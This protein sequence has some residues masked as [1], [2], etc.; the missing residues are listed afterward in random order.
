[1]ARS[2]VDPPHGPCP[3]MFSRRLCLSNSCRC[4]SPTGT[5]G[6]SVEMA[7][8]SGCVARRRRISIVSVDKSLDDAGKVVLRLACYVPSTWY[9]DYDSVV[10]PTFM[11]FDW[12]N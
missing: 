4:S 1:M 10:V 8:G 7:D 11:A 2:P 5:A 6:P 3:R 12:S 9:S